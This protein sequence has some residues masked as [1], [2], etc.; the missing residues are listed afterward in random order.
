MLRKGGV[1]G[2]EGRKACADEMV[3]KGVILIS[4]IML[5]LEVVWPIYL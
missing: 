2:E 3:G 5:L 4:S 1:L